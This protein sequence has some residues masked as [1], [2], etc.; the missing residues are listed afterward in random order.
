[1]SGS[2]PRGGWTPTY[3]T[4]RWPPAA[5]KDL[6]VFETFGQGAP[7]GSEQDIATV[8]AACHPLAA[9]IRE[10]RYVTHNGAGPRDQLQP[11][12]VAEW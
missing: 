9:C 2:S 11:V 4:C 8:P 3:R 6:V 10:I 7:K 1:M 5:H 12:V